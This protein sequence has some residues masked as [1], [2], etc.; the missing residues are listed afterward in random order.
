M[1]PPQVLDPYPRHPREDLQRFINEL[2]VKYSLGI[3]LPDPGL[4]PSKRK[5]QGNSATK[6]Y[7]R[8]QV[9]FYQGG[10]ETLHQLTEQFDI[11]ARQFW[12][13]WV[14]KPGGDQDTLPTPRTTPLAT[15]QVQRESLHT[16]FH[17]ILDRCQPKRVLSRT[18]SG[19]ASIS[20]EKSTSAQPKRAPEAEADMD[21]APMK[22]SR[23]AGQ[24][25][26]AAQDSSTSALPKPECLFAAS[27]TISKAC[28]QSS[29][30]TEDPLRESIESVFSNTK[31]EC[32]TQETVEASPQEQRRAPLSSQDHY[33]PTSTLED[34][35]YKSFDEYEAS[36]DS[37]WKDTR[38]KNAP[39][40]LTQNSNY[41]GPT[42]SALDE[43]FRLHS[44]NEQ[45]PQGEQTIAET[46]AVPQSR[47]CLGQ[48]IWPALPDWLRPAPFHIAW[49]VIRIGTHMGV[50]LSALSL[51]YSSQW[52]DQKVLR[53][54][55]GGAFPGKS[56][57]TASDPGAWAVASGCASDENQHV[58]FSASLEF[59]STR[60]G[61]TL[62]LRLQPLKLDRPHRL[63]R[64]YGADRFLELLVPSP[65]SSNLP[66]SVKDEPFDE[67]LLNWLTQKPHAFCGR[68]Y[69]PFYL[70]SGGQRKPPKRLQFGPEPKPVYTDR[71]FLFAE[72]GADLSRNKQPPTP[73]ESMV[74]WGL[75]LRRGMNN[76]QPVLKLFQ[77]LALVL[78]RT[79]PTVVFEPGQ[80]RHRTRDLRSPDGKKVMNDGVARMSKKVA[81]MIQTALG[82]SSPPC[83]VQGR[84]GSAKGMWIVDVTDT[85]DDI[86]IE[87]YPSQRKWVLEATDAEHRTLEIRSCPPEK[88]RS[89]SLNLQFL[90]VLEDRARDKQAMRT[91]IGKLL[92]KNLL[93]EFAD[94]RKSLENPIQF[95]KWISAN[96]AYSYDQLTRGHVLFQGGLPQQD[97]KTMTYMLNAGFDPRRNKFL[98]DMAYNNQLARYEKLGK[99][100]NIKVGCSAYFYMVV[101][102]EQ[103]L[104]EGEVHIGFS[105]RFRADFDEWEGTMVHGMDVLVA[106][107]PA[108]FISDIQRVR[109]VFKPELAPL[110]N[111]IVFSVKGT[112]PL[113]EKLSGGDYD[114]DQC[115][116][117]WD[118]SIVGNFENAIDQEQPDLSEYYRQDRI[119]LRQLL[120]SHNGDFGPAIGEMI[121]KCFAFNLAKDMLGQVTNYKERLCYARGNVRDDVA[122]TLS[123]LLSDLVDA[124]KQGIEFDFKSFKTFKQALK[125]P[126]HLEEPLY[127]KEKGPLLPQQQYGHIL[128]YLRFWVAKRTIDEEMGSV[129]Q[130]LETANAV[131]WDKDLTARHYD[132]WEHDST[133][134]EP[135]KTILRCLKQDIEKVLDEWNHLLR[136]SAV[137]FS[138]RA[139]RTHSS[140]LAIQPSKDVPEAV[141]ERL[142]RGYK[143][144]SEWAL[145]KASTTFKQYY[146]TKP[147]FAWQMAGWHLCYI[148]WQAVSETQADVGRMPA[149]FTSTMH[150]ITKIDKRAIDRVVEYHTSRDTDGSGDGDDDEDGEDDA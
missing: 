128:D 102:F 148:K 25:A 72:D 8:L 1:R 123:A 14:K 35:L 108:H 30:R 21:T 38:P 109:A 4:S 96:S 87:T 60:S 41:S 135:G 54:A 24:A 119:E 126:D 75:D 70:K 105:E 27:R 120:S 125:L 127:K 68:L 49:E 81:K 53:D 5:E 138:E 10:V 71:I 136:D 3:P 101:D 43:A 32:S 147:R 143:H 77:R 78:S 44:E 47:S 36:F 93:L 142:H 28:G 26:S 83:A 150:A 57:P 29:T 80:I 99:K 13:S 91:T 149:V 113:A 20:M 22:R 97:E 73:L 59:A 48:D 19:P 51:T 61:S 9:H 110:G 42:S 64:K 58:V 37:P 111:V 88:L 137:S 92:E 55:L 118:Q 23:L 100:L 114:G 124:A 17:E 39:H 84:L 34:A 121:E 141:L 140:W 90:P 62:R 145:L 15:N 40:P 133:N 132:E 130:A 104:E 86:W 52:T 11:E 89:A 2:N 134:S 103:K 63:G 56:L 112:T 116:C 31:A 106:R 129:G 18:R 74:S 85:T 6:L 65:D 117:I 98:S 115:L 146:Y 79:I 46:L 122:R 33:K 139:Q 144:T 66:L 45:Q 7:D 69:R 50:D 76:S 67:E 16:I 95:Q 107:S 12:S 131:Y 82:L 94:Q